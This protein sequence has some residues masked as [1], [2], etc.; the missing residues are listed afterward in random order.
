M[1]KFRDYCIN[2][3]N[4]LD[5]HAEDGVYTGTLREASDLANVPTHYRSQVVRQLY[6][7]GS[8]EQLQRGSGIVPTKLRIVK[9]PD[10]DGRWPRKSSLSHL[11]PRS[12]HDTLVAEVRDIQ[13]RLGS[14]NIA[15]ALFELSERVG[16]LERQINAL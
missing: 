14:L 11:T 9:P 2:L 3:Y 6:D 12:E 1:S 5:K 7:L 10:R 16:A 4:T 13:T 8:I 15:Q